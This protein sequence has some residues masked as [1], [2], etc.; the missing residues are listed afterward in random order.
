MASSE[1]REIRCA[2]RIRLSGRETAS[3]VASLLSD[4]DPTVRRNA[5][6]VVLEH[7][8]DRDVDGELPDTE[9]KAF[10]R[11]R[12]APKL[13]DL[14]LAS[15]DKQVRKMILD[16]LER[17]R[18]DD[19]KASVRQAAAEALEKIKSAESAKK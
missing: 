2:A 3:T 13:A 17:L 8:P 16:A 7:V 1:D 14:F 5:L 11:E 6:T 9:V 18:R 4:P 10:F 19:T 15:S 12:S